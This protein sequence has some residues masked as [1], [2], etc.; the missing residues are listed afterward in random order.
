[1][2]YS[3]M[4]IDLFCAQAASSSPAPGGGGV[5]ALCGALA[6]S[7]CSMVCALTQGKAKFAAFGKN[8]RECAEKA[9]ALRLR[10]LELIDGDAEAFLPLSR[11]Y[12]LPKDAPG[13]DETLESALLTAA[14]APME[15]LRLCA[16]I[17]GLCA[18]L[19]GKSS[20]LA[21]SDVGCAAALAG[22]AMK[23]AAM[24]VRVNTRL[25]KN[26]DAAAA[27][28][29]ETEA[30]LNKYLPLAEGVYEKIWSALS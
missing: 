11:A 18:R 5:S 25:M 23:S 1:M 7:L 6:A 9:E 8:T 26:R 29:D 28:D 20:T 2:P 30:L 14:S 3:D 27:I 15:M 19:E 4:N 22:A 13:R 24:N 16:D 10:L 21:A 17:A 12:A